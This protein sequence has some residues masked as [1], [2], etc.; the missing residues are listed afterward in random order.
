MKLSQTDTSAIR[1]TA[2]R[3]S[4]LAQRAAYDAYVEWMTAEVAAG[5]MTV[6]AAARM[7]LPP[8]PSPPLPAAAPATSP[9]G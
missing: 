1:R 8:A 2:H 6:E 4:M 9:A 5:R 7:Q 3:W